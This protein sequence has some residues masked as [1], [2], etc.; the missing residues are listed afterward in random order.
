MRNVRKNIPKESE[1]DLKD[2]LT[3]LQGEVLGY[4]EWPED[5]CVDV[6]NV[7]GGFMVGQI[8]RGLKKSDPYE[9]WGPFE[10]KSLK[11]LN[12]DELLERL[13]TFRKE[14]MWSERVS[15]W[16]DEGF[17]PIFVLSDPPRYGTVLLDGRG[18]FSLA[19]GLGMKT[20]P[21]Y[22]IK[23]SKCN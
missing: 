23:I 13:K 3:H 21:G 6:R 22:E 5:V 2:A 11:N 4:E 7:P 18:R 19:V 10:P 20:I 1:P 9:D 15:K 16:L 8:L 17:P 14:E 12:R